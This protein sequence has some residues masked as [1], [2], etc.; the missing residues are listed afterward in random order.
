M[1]E[2]NGNK[3]NKTKNFVKE[4]TVQKDSVQKESPEVAK[5]QV[6]KKP[7]VHV[8]Q[9]IADNT[10]KLKLSNMQRAGFRAYMENEQYKENSFDFID[11]LNKYLGK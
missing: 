4:D 11:S 7:L 9:F 10:E 1:A 3:Q 5:K 6:V 8:S 2:K